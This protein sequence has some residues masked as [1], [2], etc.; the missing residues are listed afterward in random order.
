[1]ADQRIGAIFLGSTDS[2]FQLTD[3]ANESL[4]EV[5]RSGLYLKEDGSVGFAQQIN[6]TA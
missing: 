4:G 3:Y 6:L 2:P 1:L 5:V